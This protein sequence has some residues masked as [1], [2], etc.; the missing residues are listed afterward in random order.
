MRKTSLINAVT[1][2]SALVMACCA[3]WGINAVPAGASV[4]Q[5]YIRTWDGGVP[6][7]ER[8]SQT[9]RGAT[10]DYGEP[11]SYRGATE[12]DEEPR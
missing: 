6:T 10:E 3:R 11:R 12:A 2:I 8:T 9:Y 1:R 5:G 4:Q 7:N